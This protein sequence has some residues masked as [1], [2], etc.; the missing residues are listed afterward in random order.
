MRPSCPPP[1][2]PMVLPGAMIW[3]RS[4]LMGSALLGSALMVPT[5]PWPLLLARWRF[6]DRFGLLVAIG[7]EPLAERRV[8]ERDDRRRQQSGIGGARFADGQSTNWNARRH[9]YD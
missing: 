7:I 6:G 9:L 3:P 4:T 5:N 2:M 1:R 8:V